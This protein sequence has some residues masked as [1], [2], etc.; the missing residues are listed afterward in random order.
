MKTNQTDKQELIALFYNEYNGNPVQLAAVHEFETKY[1]P[2]K[3]LWWYTRESFMHKIL[4]KALRTQNIDI[5]FLFRFIISDIDRQLKQNQCRTFVRVYRGQVMSI[6]ELDNLRKSIDNFISINSFFSTSMNQQKALGFLFRT[7]I[8]NDLCRVLFQIE[9]NSRGTSSK[10]YA[11]ISKFSCYRNEQEILFMIGCVFRL[12][13]VRRSDDGEMW[14]VR[15]R[16]CGDDEHDMKKLFDHMKKDYGGGNDE[17][18][19][20]AFGRVLRRMGKY[21]LAEKFYRRLLHDVPSNDPSLSDLFYSLGVVTMDTGDY[22]SSLQWFH[23][24]LDIIMR[25]NPS[26]YVNISSRY[27]CIGLLHWKRN[28][29]NK[30]LE[31][32]KTGIQLFEQQ[33]NSDHLSVAYFYN[34]IALVYDEQKKYEKALRFYQKTLEIYQEHL[35]SD[36]PDIG[37]A[38]DNIGIIYRSLG[39]YDL[40]MKYHD[41]SLQIRQKSLP[42][43]HTLIGFNFKNIG[44]LYESKGQLTQALDYLKKAA[45]IYSN[46][47]SSD[48]PDVKKIEH[49]IRR[50]SLKLE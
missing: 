14:I 49:D 10:P 21:E 15:M 37:T 9:A 1:S 40:A 4:N 27:C 12:I 44:L 24:S 29:Y 43:N 2:D 42:A 31:W 38:H 47:L 20:L 6:E 46:S 35:P 32:Y 19:I 41:Q 25:K 45:T 17:V 33:N 50:V 8:S 48:H 18:D 28:D 13:D 39:H 34:N 16:L 23:K 7:D 22:D 3:A 5:L 36:H 26:D 11:D 30:A